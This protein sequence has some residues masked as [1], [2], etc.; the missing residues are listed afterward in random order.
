M[1]TV[2][3]LSFAAELLQEAFSVEKNRFP[4][5]GQFSDKISELVSSL[6]AIRKLPLYAA[7]V[8]LAGNASDVPFDACTFHN[9]SAIQWAR[10]NHREDAGSEAMQL[11]TVISTVRYAEQMLQANDLEKVCEDLSQALIEQ[12][13]PFQENNRV[14]HVQAKRWS[15]ALVENPLGLEEACLTFEPLGLALIGDYISKT[16]DAEAAA[17]SALDAANRVLEMAVQRIQAGKL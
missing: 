11:W 7:C 6:G 9:S 1:L 5:L 12:I 13:K 3:T 17:L 10:L 16:A 15:E 2:V 8:V 14:M 4:E